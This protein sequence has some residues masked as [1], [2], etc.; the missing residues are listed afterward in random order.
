MGPYPH[1]APA[2]RIGEANPMGTDGFEFVE[3]AHPDPQ[4]LHDLFRAMGFTA[5][6]RHRTRAITVYRQGDVNYLV[7]EQPGT[8]GHR[9]V[10]AHGPCAPAMAFR[11]VDARHAFARAVAL[12]A[13]PAD[14]ADGDKTL[15][16]PAIKGIGGSLL[17]FVDRYGP[18][19]SPYEAEFDWLGEPDPRPEGLGLFYLDHLTHNVHRGRM[20]VWA[21]FYERLFNF[22]QIRYFDIEGKLTGLFSKALTSPDGKIRIPINESADEKSQI[23]EYLHAYNG[24]GIQH[25]ACGCR[26]IYATIEALRARGVAFMPPP[27]SVY[28]RR[29]DRRLPG[30]GEPLDRMERN[31]ILID[32][33]GVVEGGLTKILL[34]LFSA[35]AIG[36]IFFEFIQRKGDDGFGEGNFKALFESIE[37]D[38]IRRGVLAPRPEEA[39]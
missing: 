30:H 20:Q 36:P 3:Y 23:E 27:P 29:V 35:N 7:N 14:P 9:F 8:H 5:V 12:G 11:V 24:E 17:Y 1:D 16:V 15:D 28:Y 2:P 34:Q 31:G 26:D 39:A 33:E 19:G 13:E 6:A 10:A 21:G 25:I 32:G 18:K 37:E 38:Q 4:A 22:R